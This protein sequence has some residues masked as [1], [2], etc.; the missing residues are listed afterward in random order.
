MKYKITEKTIIDA[1]WDDNSHRRINRSEFYLAD[2][3]QV[4]WYI[5]E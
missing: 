5:L 1:M 4:A 3:K 2:C